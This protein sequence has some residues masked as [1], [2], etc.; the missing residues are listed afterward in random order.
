MIVDYDR[1][2]SAVGQAVKLTG[3]RDSTISKQ[4]I[5]Q[6]DKSDQ[7]MW[8]TWSENGTQQFAGFRSQAVGALRITGPPSEDAQVIACGKCEWVS[9]TKLRTVYAVDFLSG[10]ARLQISATCP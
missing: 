6:I 9:A 5:G 1:Q 3:F 2:E 4:C 10:P 8:M 7:G